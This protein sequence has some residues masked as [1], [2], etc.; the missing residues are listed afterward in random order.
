MLKYKTVLDGIV[1]PYTPS[2]TVRILISQTHTKCILAWL[3]P[4]SCRL[5]PNVSSHG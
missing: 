3:G 4:H 1:C 5:P 2:S